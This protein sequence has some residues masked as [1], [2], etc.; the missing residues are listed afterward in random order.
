MRRVLITGGR[1]QLAYD[2]QRRWRER[3]PND[4]LIA[5]GHGD[6]D[7]TDVDAIG[8]VFDAQ[9]PGLLINCAA[10]HVVD[11]VE[12]YPDKAFLVNAIA[13]RNLAVACRERDVPMVH[14]STD[15]VFSGDRQRRP[16]IE[17][18]AVDPPN[19]YGVS[20]AAGELVLRLAWRRHY[21]VRGS[22][23]YGVAGSS[24][25]GGNFVETMLKLASQGKPI[26]VVNDQVLTPTSTWF[27]ADQIALLVGT[28]SYGT[29]HATCQG[30]CS[31]FDFAAEIF[32]ETGLH[33]DLQ[34]TT[35][36]ERVTPARRPAYSVL[37]NRNL[38]RLGIDVMPD[39]KEALRFYLA[40]RHAHARAAI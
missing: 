14:L 12:S 24:G 30:Q 4:E 18:E 5:L 35:S 16:H 36:A 37:E 26:K 20:K 1:G 39:W 28:D 40:E 15:Y 32:R 2:L 27:L 9:R 38:K 17:D 22:G 13:V 7:I 21:I 6:L 25:K 3:H 29:Y 31:W 19:V 34:P 11:E 10:Y 23:L 8:R 33:P